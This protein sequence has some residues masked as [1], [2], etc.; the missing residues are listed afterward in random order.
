MGETIKLTAADGHELD[1]YRADPPGVSKGGI[2]VIQ[3][4]FGVNVHVRDVCDRLAGE[5]YTAL[6]PALFD[7]IRRGIE[8]GYSEDDLGEGIG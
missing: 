6:A 3:E 5:G 2:V 7:R 8:L 1:A 4:I